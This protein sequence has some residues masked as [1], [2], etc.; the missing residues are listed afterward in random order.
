MTVETV[1]RKIE[2]HCREEQAAYENYQP[3][4]PYMK[5][6]KAEARGCTDMCKEIRTLC[7]SIRK[8]ARKEQP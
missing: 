5:G 1:L 4:K 7:R 2:R 6:A 3:P 8:E